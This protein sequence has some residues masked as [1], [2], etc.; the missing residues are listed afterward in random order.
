MK[1]VYIVRC[2]RSDERPDEEYRYINVSE[3]RKHY[4]AYQNDTNITYFAMQLIEQGESSTIKAISFLGLSEAEK[5]VIFNEG[6]SRQLDT[7]LR[8]AQIISQ[9]SDDTEKEIAITARI[10]VE[11]LS[12]VKFPIFFALLKNEMRA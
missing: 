8:L 12:P 4:K 2:L 11:N 6:C 5:R 9:L 10:K 7:C 1:K 3:A